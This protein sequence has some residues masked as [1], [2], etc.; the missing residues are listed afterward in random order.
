MRQSFGNPILLQQA[1]TETDA[2]EWVHL[3]PA[4]VVRT[5]DARGPYLVEDPAAVVAA[6]QA[7]RD[8]LSI[9][10]NHA[11]DHQAPAG[12][13]APSV[14]QV[15]EL[16]ARP[17]GVWGRVR[18][19]PRGRRLVADREY[20]GIS[21]VFMADAAKRV[22]RLLGASLVNRPNLRGLV[23][24]NQETA[25]MDLREMLIEALGLDP[26]SAP[27]DDAIVAAVKE[28]KGGGAE[29]AAMQS[30]L[31]DLR[32]ALGV[33]AGGD[34]VAAARAAKAGPDAGAVVA[35]Q[36]ELARVGGELATMREAG[37]RSRAEAVIDAAIREGRVGVKPL[38]DHYVSR[39]MA[40]PAAVEKEIAVLPSLTA[41]GGLINPAPP[42]TGGGV[43]LNA[44]E[45][46][47]A[48]Q[49]GMTAEEFTKAREAR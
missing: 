6:T 3:V 5:V 47:V 32:T 40:D 42:T 29:V 30:Q 4:G 33:E 19:T 21:P 9:D 23:A 35:L 18:W 14:G 41:T 31:A 49:L 10:I 38:R 28:M 44:E 16:E 34:V 8:W 24:L 37:A 22:V 25:S 13:E 2:P 1:E 39:H 36:Q 43:A 11:E 12:G 20:L 45:M 7:A 46:A 48:A 15:T 17:D 26:A 27:T